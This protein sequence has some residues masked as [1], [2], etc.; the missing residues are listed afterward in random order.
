MRVYVTFICLLFIRDINMYNL[1]DTVDFGDMYGNGGNGINEASDSGVF[2]WDSSLYGK[3]ICV[4]V[5]SN[6][7]LCKNMN[8][9]RMKMPNLLGHDTIEEIVYQS[10]VWLPL[11]SINCHRDAQ[12]FLCSMFA[13]VCVAESQAQTIYPCRSLCEAVKNSCEAKMLAYNYPWPSM[14]NCSRLPQDN[15]LCIQLSANQDQARPVSTPVDI[16]T[17]ITTTTSSSS[18]LTTR[19]TS[20]STNMVRY[21]TTT[22]TNPNLNPLIKDI[23]LSNSSF[24]KTIIQQN[25]ID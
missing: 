25:Q 11:L 20:S 12:L 22:N 18:S 4:K 6:M 2:E 10:S 8:Y 5:P 23:N 24:Y 17:T 21:R 13:P 14:F 15:G 9:P 7:T 1:M 19:R 16:T 3:P